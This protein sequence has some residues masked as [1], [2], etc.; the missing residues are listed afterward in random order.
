MKLE[1]ATKELKNFKGGTGT[2]LLT[3]VL[4]SDILVDKCRIYGKAVLK[5][6]CSVGVHTHH[7]DG[8]SFYVLSG[9]GMFTDDDKTYEIKAGDSVFCPDGHA[10]GLVNPY[11]EDLVFMALI[12]YK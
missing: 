11:E 1:V 5:K 6:G 8:E 3:P 12:I 2:M 9:R 7:G 4:G 10:H